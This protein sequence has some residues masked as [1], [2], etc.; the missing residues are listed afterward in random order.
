MGLFLCVLPRGTTGVVTAKEA[1]AARS[2]A[3]HRSQQKTKAVLLQPT[4][5]IP[6]TQL[7]FHCLQPRG[8]S[9]PKLNLPYRVLAKQGMAPGIKRVLR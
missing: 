1:T 6:K 5:N 9:A 2:I 3:N 7:T 4:S 8:T